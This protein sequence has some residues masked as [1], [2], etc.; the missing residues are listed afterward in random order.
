M[1]F[2]NAMRTTP[3]GTDTKALQKNT[4]ATKTDARDEY[5][6]EHRCQYLYDNDYDMH[7]QF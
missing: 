4:I 3:I 1:I 6:Y 5:H 2:T 7:V